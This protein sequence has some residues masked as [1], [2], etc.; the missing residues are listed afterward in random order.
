M[1]E[2]VIDVGLLWCGLM[3]IMEGELIDFHFIELGA[4]ENQFFLVQKVRTEV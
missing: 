2:E 1:E 4:E 3:E